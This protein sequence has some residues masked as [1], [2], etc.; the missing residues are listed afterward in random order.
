MRSAVAQHASAAG[1]LAIAGVHVVWATG[2]SWPMRDGDALA[3]TAGGGRSHTAT[4]CLAV[5]GLL[6]TASALVAGHPRRAPR[7][8][9]AGAGTV[10]AVLAT[11]G[12]FGLAGRTDALV[13][14][15]S[16]ARFR[17]LDRRYYAP[18]CLV[19]AAGALPAAANG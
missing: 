7:L 8:Q 17:R 10:A 2:S 1:L 5:A 9:R 19:L 16:S 11:R 18:L 4:E 6:T 14:G 13:P 15:S 12:A 3:Q